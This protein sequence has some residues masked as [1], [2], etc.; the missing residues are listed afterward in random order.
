MISLR[1]DIELAKNRR[2][3]LTLPILSQRCRAKVL[4]FYHSFQLDP[5]ALA[6]ISAITLGYKAFLSDDQEAFE[7][8][9]TAHVLAVSGLHVGIIYAVIN[10]LF[11]FLGKRG[12]PFVVRQ[13]LV[14][15]TLWAYALIA[16]M[17]APITRASFMLTVYCVGRIL[18][19]S[20]FTYNTLAAAAF[21]I[22][23]F[24]PFSLFDVSFLM[25]FMAV[26]A[27]LFFQ[28]K[29]RQLYTPRNRVS[30]FFGDFSTI[31]LSA[32]IGVF[33]LVLYFFG[34]FPTYSFMQPIDRT[35]DIARRN[36]PWCAYSS[37]FLQSPCHGW[38]RHSVGI[39]N[40]IDR[41]GGWYSSGRSFAQVTDNIFLHS[42]SSFFIYLLRNIS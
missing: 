6:F 1:T 8:S 10:L 4:T 18:K 38:K 15:L 26:F 11:S 40:A 20:G 24:K 16:G 34:S 30:K 12:R 3:R 21:I 27:I 19:R 39:K 14:I 2:Q 28:P 31:S 32:Q 5:D 41:V 29:L 17:S 33:P 37:S 36:R 9:G 22:L 25:S 23:L 42:S 13:L 35:A 7:P